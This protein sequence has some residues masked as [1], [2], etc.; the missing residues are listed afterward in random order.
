MSGFFTD[1]NTKGT[2]TNE[3]FVQYDQCLWVQPISGNDT[4][5]GQSIQQPLKTLTKA[6]Q[7][8]G[9][10]NTIIYLANG[11][12]S[13]TVTITNNAI[14]IVGMSTR[15]STAQLTGSITV[16]NS[17]FL[18][19]ESVGVQNTMTISNGLVNLYQC[20]LNGLIIANGSVTAVNTDFSGA[21][22]PNPLSITGGQLITFTCKLTTLNIANG[23][24][25]DQNSIQQ[26]TITQNGGN[27]AL[28]GTN[29]IMGTTTG[30]AINVTGGSALIKDVSCYYSNGTLSKISVSAGASFSLSD[31]IFDYTNSSLLGTKINN[32]STFNN[33]ALLTTNISRAGGSL[34]VA[35]VP[36][37]GAIPVAGNTNA[38]TPQVILAGANTT[39]TN[40]PNNVQIDFTVTGNVQQWVQTNAYT[41][42][43]VVIYPSANYASYAGA[44]KF[45][46]AN[47]AIPANTSFT[48]GLTGATWQLLSQWTQ[49]LNVY[50]VTSGVS[51]VLPAPITNYNYIK[52]TAT[53]YGLSFTLPTYAVNLSKTFEIVN[54][55][56][57]PFTMYGCNVAVGGALSLVWN[58]SNYYPVTTTGSENSIWRSFSPNFNTTS[59]TPLFN[60]PVF[61]PNNYG[62]YYISNKTMFLNAFWGINGG[63]IANTGSGFYTIAVP[64]SY[65]INSSIATGNAS[66]TPLGRMTV[67]NGFWY[68]GS[69]TG[70]ISVEPYDQ[71]RLCFTLGTIDNGSFGIAKMQ[72]MSN[73]WGALNLTNGA[74]GFGFQATIPLV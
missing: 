26:S 16:N 29:V 54:S 7:I 32:P 9:N 31:V 62:S 40:T 15:S 47:D 67:G 53:A 50:Q 49:G 5:T 24:V 73:S 2:A 45:Y 44:P 36:A 58:G 21:V 34:G 6:L 56:T 18:N 39:I 23:T 46:I 41:Q 11:S 42:G 27:L 48:L 28:T 65:Q 14:N 66:N 20:Q 8:A 51:I 1:I 70:V 10:K 13:D 68:N 71:S 25:I 38:Y 43:Q 63:S 61:S 57:Y 22:T 52:I 74:W 33:I 60:N 64:A 30:N 4:N 17:G 72:G 35:T 69:R 12:Y 19:L 37:N 3:G 59:N 55:G